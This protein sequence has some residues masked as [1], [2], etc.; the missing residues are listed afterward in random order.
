MAENTDYSKYILPGGLLLIG[1]TVAQKFGLLPSLDSQEKEKKKLAASGLIDSTYVTKL[2][3]ATKKD[4]SKTGVHLLTSSG[5]NNFAKKIY[6]AIHWYKND[7]AE[8]LSV[9]RLIEFKSQ[10]S[11]VAQ[12]FYKLYGYDMYTYLSQKCSDATIA[13]VYDLINSKETGAY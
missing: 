5:A 13:S 8:I 10:V 2:I 11:Q 6:D 7:S 4:S 12:A 9:F 1:V 3:N